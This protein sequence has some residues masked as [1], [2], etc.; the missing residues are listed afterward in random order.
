[1]KVI[2]QGGQSIF[3]RILS[4]IIDLITQYGDIYLKAFPRV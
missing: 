1:M 3:R 4:R 2:D